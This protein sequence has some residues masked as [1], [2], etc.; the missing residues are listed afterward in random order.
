MEHPHTTISEVQERL[1][2]ACGRAG[3]LKRFMDFMQDLQRFFPSRGE[4][5]GLSYPTLR[6]VYH[7]TEHDTASFSMDTLYRVHLMV[8]D[9]ER[10]KS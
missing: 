1:V 6:K 7:W 8:E 9:F 5:D 2:K 3:N 10:N 4:W